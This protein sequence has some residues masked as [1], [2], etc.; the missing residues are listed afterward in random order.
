MGM[1]PIL[2]ALYWM[3]R[4][5]GKD[6]WKVSFSNLP[7]WKEFV[8]FAV[9][10]N[11]S[12]TINI[13]ARDSEMQWIGLFF[14]PEAAGLYKVAL[15][16]I[17]LIIMPIDPFIATTYPEILRAYAMHQWER[18]RSLLKR[19]TLISFSWTGAVAIGLI[20]IGKQVLF[21]NWVI[22]GHTLHLYDPKYLPA[23]PI[24]LVILV[25][26][27]VANTLFWNRSLLLAQ[28]KANEALWIAFFAMLAKVS[29]AIII[30]PRA[31]YIAEAF[32]LSGYFI[33]SI[34]VQAWRGL[35]L[36]KRQAEK[37][38]EPLLADPK[39]V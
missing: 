29:L 20:L 28:G 24:L 30:L 25:G 12:G 8:R 1:G 38:P 37:E 39:S 16:L 11:F 10:T 32:I 23:Y 17:G 27:G 21:S 31:P 19:V 26:Y 13:F 2:L 36:M 14:G 15:A 18:L 33:V 35:S 22:F 3:P 9:S 6:W 7:P 4:T 5:L 34:G